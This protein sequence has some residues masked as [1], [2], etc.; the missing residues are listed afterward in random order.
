MLT[1]WRSVHLEIDSMKPAP[2]D[3]AADERTFVD[4]EVK[5][6]LPRDDLAF[7]ERLTLK[8]KSPPGMTGLRNQSADRDRTGSDH[9]RH[10]QGLWTE[11]QKNGFF[12]NIGGINWPIAKGG[13]G[14]LVQRGDNV[15]VGEVIHGCKPDTPVPIGG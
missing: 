8:P 3:P 13:V 6:V 1:I 5:E 10:Q 2:L 12:L 14:P 11:A 7:V 9:F 4:G 15:W